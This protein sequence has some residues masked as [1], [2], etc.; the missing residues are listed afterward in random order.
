MLKLEEIQKA[1]ADRNLRKVARAV[2]LSYITVWRVAN[3]KIVE[4][5]YST[6]EKLSDYLT[7]EK[8]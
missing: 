2:D 7:G 3:G 6:I 5:S 8:K 1:L 4:V